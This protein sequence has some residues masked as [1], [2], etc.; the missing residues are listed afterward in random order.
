MA[1]VFLICGKI[2]CG[3]TTYSEKL[4]MDNNAILLSV[5][6]VMLTLFGQHCGNKHNEYTRKSKKYLLSK[7]LELID[8]NVNVVLD[9]GFW[10]KTER[11]AIKEYYEFR[12]IDCEL[13]Y[14]N[15]NDEVWKCR[16]ADRNL[17][18]LADETIAYYVDDIIAAKFDSMFEVP[19]EDEIDLIIEE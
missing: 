5:D 15:I 11:K 10:A 1:K 4:C 2:C 7:S 13:H 16:I 8:K 12:G 6:E 18:V 19:T 17:S 3:K 9:W 14:I